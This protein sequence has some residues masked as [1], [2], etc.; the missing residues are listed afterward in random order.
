VTPEKETLPWW[1]LNWQVSLI[2]VNFHRSWNHCSKGDNGLLQWNKKGEGCFS[3]TGVNLWEI[4]C[5]GV[6]KWA[7]SLWLGY[8]CLL[9]VISPYQ[10]Q[11]PRAPKD[12][13]SKD[14]SWELYFKGM[15]PKTL[16]KAYW[17]VKLASDWKNTCVSKEQEKNLQL[18]F[19]K[20]NA[21]RKGNPGT[22]NQEAACL[23]SSQAEGTLKLSRSPHILLLVRALKAKCCL[24]RFLPC[25]FY[26]SSPQS[27][28]P[29]KAPCHALSIYT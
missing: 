16:R 17:A 29:A 7:S 18:H 10:S 27:W 3:S 1:K 14:L 6:S 9:I 12:R 2:S 28:D 8:K 23:K 26:C 22:Y 24:H 19:S 21:L 13:A 4:N 5:E 11:A 20:G 15:A 25:W